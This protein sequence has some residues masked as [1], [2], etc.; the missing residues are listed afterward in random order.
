MNQY[1]DKHDRPQ[2]ETFQALL[3]L[4]NIGLRDKAITD[5]SVYENCYRVEVSGFCYKTYY[6]ISKFDSRVMPVKSL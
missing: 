1:G 2:L 6:Q 3:N 4:A 5:F